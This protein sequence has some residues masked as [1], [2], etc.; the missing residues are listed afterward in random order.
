MVCLDRSLHP[1]IPIRLGRGDV[2]EVAPDQHIGRSK[3]VMLQRLDAGYKRV[4]VKFTSI[5]T[6]FWS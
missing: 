6:S 5:P 2:A 3:P 4:T 1:L